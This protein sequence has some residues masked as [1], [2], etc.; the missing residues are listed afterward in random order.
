MSLE[1]LMRVPIEVA[2]GIAQP[3]S[4]APAVVSVITADEIKA[5]GALT[6]SEV[7]EMV[8]GIHAY[9]GRDISQRTNYSVRG[10]RS[11]ANTQFLV[12]VDGVPITE[13]NHGG[14]P[15][16]F[17]LP[18]NAIARVE[19]IRGP[20][21]AVYGADAFAGLV[22][23]ISKDAQDMD[24]AE[25][26]LRGG[27]F[28]TWNTWA[29]WG[30]PVGSWD[31]SISAEWLKSDGDED[32]IINSD[33]QS[34]FDEV[35]FGT[36]ASLTPGSLSTRFDVANFHLGLERDSWEINLWAMDNKDHGITLGAANAL[37]PTG[38][39]D[40]KSLLADISFAKDLSD[41]WKLTT[42]LSHLYLDAEATLVLFPPG[43]VILVGEDGNIFS[44]PFAGA[45]FFS[46]GVIGIP[47]QKERTTT[48]EAYATH[49]GSEKH[50]FRMGLG[51]QNMEMK[52]REKKNFGPGVLDIN[53]VG[54]PLPQVVDG[55]L[56]NVTGT[57]AVYLPDSDRDHWYLSLQDVWTL[58][59]SWEATLGVRYDDYSDFG[60]TINPRLALVWSGA[61]D[62]IVKL[63]YGTAFRAP[64]YGELFARNN[65]AAVGTPT[66]Q[67]EEIQTS[68]LVFDYTPSRKLRMI[69]NLYYSNIDGLIDLIPDPPPASTSHYLNARD[70][71]SY[72]L[73]LEWYWNVS[74]EFR[75]RGYYAYQNSKD[76]DTDALVPYIP[77]DQFFLAAHW[78]P[79]KDW[80]F[81][82]KA[83]WIND[84]ERVLGD[85]REPLDGHTRVDLTLG[86]NNI[87]A[88]FDLAIAVRNVFDEDG[89]D[90]SV[91]IDVPDDMLIEGRRY[92]VELRCRF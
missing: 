89:R 27:S 35:V 53:T 37:D 32:R 22:N 19:V 73:E 68:E 28:S 29:Q 70:Q 84:M 48:L 74:S 24:G 15:L 1:Q 81:T 71:K 38:H 58:S 61:S 80:Y 50:Q 90:P 18:V 47:G 16:Q 39:G 4:E 65:P 83:K 40:A 36:D 31:M 86:R 52:P 23:I 21:S 57:D 30:G 76:K 72:G 54:F 41:D 5:M 11:T 75:I 14:Q 88:N 60:D 62:L 43:A 7:L 69:L 85:P 25:L 49:S 46:D 33:L 6:L 45:P 26:G 17:T 79:T 66:I 64:A 56:T 12:M 63:L 82:T 3:I 10:I 78:I 77:K 8:P 34:F 55:T 42:R 44:P 9:A 67:P 20:G 59:D 51:Y 87:G 92:T 91:S 2:T 13:M